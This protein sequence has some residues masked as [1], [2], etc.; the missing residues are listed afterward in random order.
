[1]IGL[2]P[3]RVPTVNSRSIRQ[4]NSVPIMLLVY[5]DRE[6]SVGTG[7]AGLLTRELR[8]RLVAIQ[9][10]EAP[11]VHGWLTVV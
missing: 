1:M 5:R 8:Q 10:G 2:I 11:D 4:A 3:S 7:D 6:Y 9:R